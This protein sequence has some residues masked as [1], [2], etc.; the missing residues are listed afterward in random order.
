M[1]GLALQL[2]E[3]KSM[4]LLRIVPILVLLGVVG[5]AI[6]GAANSLPIQANSLVAGDAQ[7]THC[8][9]DGVQVYWRTEWNKTQNL[10][11]LRGVNI[12]GINFRCAGQAADV[13]ITGKSGSKLAEVKTQVPCDPAGSSECDTNIRI[14]LTKCPPGQID[15]TQNGCMPL[16]TDVNDIHIAI[17]N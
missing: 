3:E 17:H 2:Y 10:L 8:D 13:I 14:E 7:V 5:T 16:A 12:T 9:T 15:P 11:L 6:W 1:S 4:K